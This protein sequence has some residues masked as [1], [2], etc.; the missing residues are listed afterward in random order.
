[1]RLPFQIVH[2]FCQ[3]LSHGLADDDIIEASGCCFQEYSIKKQKQVF[4]G[5]RSSQV[6]A[7]KLV[8]FK[9]ILQKQKKG[10]LGSS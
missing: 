6:K 3:P 8:A 4:L 5:P 9:N 10:V 2:N 7:D 1:M